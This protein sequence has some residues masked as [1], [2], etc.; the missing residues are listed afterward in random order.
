MKY[1]LKKLSQK[2]KVLGSASPKKKQKKHGFE[3]PP[4]KLRLVKTMYETSMKKGF[5]SIHRT[6]SRLDEI[7]EQK[8]GKCGEKYGNDS[9]S[10]TERT[11]NLSVAVGFFFLFSSSFFFVTT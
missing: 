8:F 10:P 11:R 5:Q 4:S 9:P 7:R 2:P 1:H 6:N 3:S